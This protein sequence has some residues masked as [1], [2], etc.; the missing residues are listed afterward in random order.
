MKLCIIIPG[1]WSRIMGG[2]QYQVKCLIEELNKLNR[3]EIF[4]ISR[5]CDS[6]YK[7]VCYQLIRL[8]YPGVYKRGLHRHLIEIVVLQKL[9]KSIKPHII[10]QR[11]GCAQT[12]IAAR[13][14]KKSGCKLFWHVSSENDL[15]PN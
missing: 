6:N 7:P 8:Q 15:C 10:Y 14:A 3:F 1:H 13:Y 2:A 11:V 9:L 5:D 12:G 4:N